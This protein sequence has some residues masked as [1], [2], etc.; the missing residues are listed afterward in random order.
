[1]AKLI[2]L[3]KDSIRVEGVDA[4]GIRIRKRLSRKRDPDFE[5]SANKLMKELKACESKRLLESMGVIETAHNKNSK[6][7]NTMTFADLAAPYREYLLTTRAGDNTCY[8]DYLVDKYGKKRL[9]QVSLS[10][11]RE[12]LWHLLDHPIGNRE[13]PLAPSSIVKLM[14]YMSRIYGYGIEREVIDKNPFTRISTR[15]FA[16]EL[17]RRNTFKPVVL[18]ADEFW[19][20]VQTFP[21]YAKNPAVVAFFSGMRRSEVVGCR[22]SMVDLK[23]HR[24]RYNA[25][26]V[27]EADQKTVYYDN[28]AH[29]VFTAL[30]MDRLVNGYQ[31]DYVFR[32]V[33]GGPMTDDS[34]SFSVRYYAD[35]YADKTGNDKFRQVTMHTFRRSYRTRK[36]IEGVD[37][38]AVRAN[39]GH[40]SAAT[41]EIYDIVDDDRLRAVAGTSSMHPEIEEKLSKEVEEMQKKGLSLSDMQAIVRKLWSQGVKK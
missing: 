17:K 18:S 15:N 2:Y 14:R 3:D 6:V 28:E 41:S 39:M 40:H 35:K 22:W 24:I 1:V 12:W 31:D 19:S 36:K 4:N 32:N 8:V 9:S 23:M 7:W 33:Q 11:F 21:P 13:D 37:D 38:R 5:K 16:K 10:G 34:L 20:M 25:S 29:E 26:E 30:E 27:K